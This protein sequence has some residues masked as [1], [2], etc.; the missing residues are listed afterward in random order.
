[1]PT[2]P[3]TGKAL[4]LS[5]LSRSGDGRFLFVPM[6][7]SV[8][9]GP[10]VPS[11]RFGGL[12]RDVAAGGA[13][14]IIVHKGRARALDPAVLRTTALI[15]HLSGSTAFAPDTNAKV[16]VGT[17]E[18]A[19]RLGADAV[20]VHLNLGA[21]TESGQL[22]DIGRVA[23]EADRWGMPLIVMAYARGPRVPE[24]LDAALVAHVVNVAADLGADVVKTA[25]P[26]PSGG[27]AEVVANSPVP[28]IVAGGADDGS[29]VLG[30]GR[31]MMA[32][33]CGGLAVGRRVFRSAAPR[34]LVRELT[35]VVHGPLAADWSEMDSDLPMGG[36]R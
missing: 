26:W 34:R 35:L 21:P 24:Q 16:L 17:V 6:D 32:A 15:V 13:D 1:V 18:E 9:D 11:A 20:S 31:A 14:A 25:V 8:S 3:L 19:V 4:R 29:D 23:A 33:G 28:V 10:I 27:I 2:A 5:R 12:V 36:L 22:A 7:H 30:F